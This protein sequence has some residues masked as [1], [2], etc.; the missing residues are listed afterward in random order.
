MNK[1][2]IGLLAILGTFFL[3]GSST[4]LAQGGNRGFQEGLHY[5]AIENAPIATGDTV[6][7]AEAF[8]YMCSHCASFE[9]YISSWQQ[10]KPA[11]VTFR[12]IPVV[13]GRGSWEVY[14]RAYV[15]AEVMGI[16]D[17]AHGAL[18]DKLWKEKKV[19]RSVEELGE[20]Y[21]EFG[22]SP[23]TFVAT[24]KSFAV[25][26]KIRKDQRDLQFASVRGTPSMIVNQKYLVTSGNAVGSYDVMLDVVDYLVTLELAELAATAAAQQA[27][28][29]EASAEGD[30]QADAEV[31]EQS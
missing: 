3:A 28:A 25:D 12:R 27:P 2:V 16:A 24:S 20:F 4:V 18:M 22:V 29:E 19:F 26:A 9:P 11:N 14:A 13:F 1:K 7:V 30:V 21:S 10:R 8:S 23:A 31:D 15:T 6:Q 17:E 5:Q